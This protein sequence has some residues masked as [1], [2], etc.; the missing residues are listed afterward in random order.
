VP[1]MNIGTEAETHREFDAGFRQKLARLL[2]WRR[3]VR[4]LRADPLPAGCIERLP[5]LAYLALAVGLSLPRRFVLIEHPSKRKRIRENFAGANAEALASYLGDRAQSG[6]LFYW[7]S[8][9][10]I[11]RS[12]FFTQPAICSALWSTVRPLVSTAA[13]AR[14]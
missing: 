2:A 7:A 4:R 13:P 3:D 11:S 6:G 14:A 12:I 8:A 10:S 5:G 1:I 9:K